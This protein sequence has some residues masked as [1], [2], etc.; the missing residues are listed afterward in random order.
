MI[1]DQTIKY[2]RI[3]GFEANQWWKKNLKCLGTWNFKLK[4]DSEILKIVSEMIITAY[5]RA[6]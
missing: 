3:V 1:I 5:V 2:Q 4:I 6:F